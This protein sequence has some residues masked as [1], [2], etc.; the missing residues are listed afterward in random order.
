MRLKLG[1][2]KGA[3]VNVHLLVSPEDPNH[4]DEVKRF[5]S[6]LT[7]RAFEE[8]FCCS[9]ADLVRLGRRADATLQGD[10]A[11]LEHGSEQ[12]KVSFD[13][14]QDKYRDSAWAQSNILVA[15][16]GGTTD[17]TSGVRDAADTTLR[18][19]VEKFAHIV[20]TSSPSAREFWLGQKDLT[21]NE[22]RRRYN[23]PKPCLHGSDAHK[24]ET[25]G[26]PNL[27]RYSWIK[28]AV[29][30]DSL[31]QACIEPAGRAY[32]GTAPPIAAT[33]SQVISRLTISGAPWMTTP[34]L[35][36]NPGLVAVIG[37]RGS[38][39]TALADII[40]AGCDTIPDWRNLQSF[41]YRAREYL[42]G[43]SVTLEWEAGDAVTR[44]LDHTYPEYGVHY[45]R[46]R[47]L[48]QQFVEELCASE[49]MTDALLRE[50]ERVVFEAH[51]AS[52]RD[53]A[54][55]F[56]ELIDLRSARHRQSRLRE[57]EALALL[58]DHIGTELE[59][60]RL[61]VPLKAQLAEKG[62]QIARYTADRGK[63]VATGSEERIARL[64]IL[65]KAAEKVRGR[66]RSL[67]IREQSLLT[68]Q[69]EVRDVRNNRSPEALRGM[70]ARYAPSGFE[71]NDW[72]RF[73]LDF[74]GD[75]DGLV[76]E[77]IARVRKSTESWM[78]TTPNATLN[79]EESLIAGDA[80]P[81]R[82]PLGLLQ[83]E[84]QSPRKTGQP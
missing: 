1:T 14:L 67:K 75:V 29:I 63:L 57:E 82:V 2:V 23:G 35:E 47:Y 61:V 43:A 54:V 62:Q 4:V 71:S 68:L 21:P 30:F 81:E 64:A 12:F 80:D 16:A 18:Q 20:F 51:D 70:Q 3:W 17:G 6:R 41:L 44:P 76:D 8:T 24:H 74:I 46:A 45:P 60:E 65:A 79:S 10:E 31:H 5:L 25:V 32:V 49:G 56:S 19:E 66:L 52:A 59:K 42:P 55:D 28:G 50:M 26:V 33:P 58:S 78:G 83:A 34:T 38:G 9:Y 53:G 22:I 7:F 27:D 72:A 36:L 13:E 73:L 77:R 40:A 11:A 48:S 39:K 37:A 15:V 69:D 84:S